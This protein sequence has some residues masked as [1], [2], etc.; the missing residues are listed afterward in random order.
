MSEVKKKK[1][2]F[3]NLFYMKYLKIVAIIAKI[4]QNKDC[5]KSRISKI[6]V[7]LRFFC[8]T[9]IKELRPKC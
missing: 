3:K 1:V 2:K 6:K 4:R 9:I 5:Q 8:N 7:S